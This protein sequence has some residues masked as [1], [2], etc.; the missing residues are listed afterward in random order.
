MSHLFRAVLQPEQSTLKD[1]EVVKGV[2]IKV[3]VNML[4]QFL[5]AVWSIRNR[6]THASV[7]YSVH[8]G[9]TFSKPDSDGH[10]K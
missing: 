5:L 9:I 8:S 1:E 4:N 3:P 6:D 10:F 2:N 7:P